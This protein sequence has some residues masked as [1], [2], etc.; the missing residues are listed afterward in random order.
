M[1]ALD[2]RDGFERV[3]RGESDLLI[4]SFRNIPK[5]RA[6]RG[7]GLGARLDKMKA[8]ATVERGVAAL[9]RAQDVRGQPPVPGSSLHEI[10]RGLG[11]GDWA[12]GL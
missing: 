5:R 8:D 12:L 9:R 3:D 11:A 4:G 10:E 6:L 2:K 7:A 1:V